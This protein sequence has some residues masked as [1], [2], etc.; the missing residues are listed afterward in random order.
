M[1]LS[2]SMYEGLSQTS[3]L[4]FFFFNYFFICALCA[5]V[6]KIRHCND[7]TKIKTECAVVVGWWIFSN[8]PLFIVYYIID[9]HTC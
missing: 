2:P 6:Y 9:V 5:M 8:V 3:T 4:S 1:L 7:S